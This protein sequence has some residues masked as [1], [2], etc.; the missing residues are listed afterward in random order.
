[1]SDLASQ[2]AP[3]AR[4]WDML[5]FL[6]AV[7]VGIVMC[8]PY[9][10]DWD[11]FDYTVF[12]LRGQPSSLASG[13]M[14]FV[15]M[16]AA[17]WRIAHHLFGLEPARAWELFRGLTLVLGGLGAVALFRATFH[18]TRSM[19][20]ALLA[21][22]IWL[23]APQPMVYAGSIMTETPTMLLFASAILSMELAVASRHTARFV[24]LAALAGGLF[25]IACNMREPL[26]CFAVYFAGRCVL[27]EGKSGSARVG[28]CAAGLVGFALLSLAGIG[29]A[30]W[31]LGSWHE[32]W[33]SFRGWQNQ[34]AEERREYPNSIPSNAIHILLY[35]GTVSVIAVFWSIPALVRG[36]RGLL[37]RP[38]AG[39]PS[40]IRWHPLFTLLAGDA[41]YL[42][43]LLGNHDTGV[44]PRFAMPLMMPL[45]ILAAATLADAVQR[46][47]RRW[48]V[49]LLACAFGAMLLVAASAT[50]Q[51]SSYLPPPGDAP[52]ETWAMFLMIGTLIAL[53]GRKAMTLPANRPVAAAATGAVIPVLAG[54]FVLVAGWPLIDY[55]YYS[56]SR[57]HQSF[58]QA[59][60]APGAMPDDAMFIPS[61]E[62]PAMQY[63]IWTGQR[64]G[65]VLPGLP[66]NRDQVLADA[67]AAK[68][69]AI[70]TSGWNWPDG[71]DFDDK[72][73]PGRKV[74][75]MELVDRY[76]AAGKPVYVYAGPSSWVP[77]KGR[78]IEWPQIR[79]LQEQRLIEADGPGDMARVSTTQP[80]PGTAFCPL[81]WRQ[82]VIRG[83]RALRPDEWQTVARSPVATTQGE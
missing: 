16:H 35:A 56:R 46:R 70:I 78:K 17:A 3:P 58:V 4:Y 1:M 52:V 77:G 67:A 14:F 48:M 40:A 64:P 12:A 63:L 39:Q 62:T 23:T 74:T 21:G 41:L 83:E 65:W 33:T 36:F 60:T 25:A 22:L 6:A 49:T 42:V 72:P 9:L 80:E 47:D 8:P 61:G 82:R 7:G 28:A 2:A 29:L 37:R 75:L 31:R 44:N 53:A 30:A 34:M 66:Y 69:W 50:W 68:G 27:A 76:Q 24:L 51:F 71:L 19:Y 32:W 73:G 45:M 18:M 54:V 20:A 81:G 38:I 11:S 26:V 43:S 10:T 5:F 55:H 57:E 15:G 59:V 79:N 13:R